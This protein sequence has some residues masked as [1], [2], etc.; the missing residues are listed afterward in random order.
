MRFLLTAAAALSS[1]LATD[2]L[3]SAFEPIDFDVTKALL[4][5]GVDVATIPGLARLASFSSPAACSIAVSLRLSYAARLAPMLITQPVLC[6][7]AY[8]R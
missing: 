4:E 6:S 1:V 5:Q 3:A 2:A 7:R 8:F